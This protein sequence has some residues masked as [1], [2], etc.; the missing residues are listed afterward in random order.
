MERVVSGMLAF[1]DKYMFW[2]D[3]PSVTVID[4]VEIILI[5]FLLY[6]ILVWIKNTRAWA[7]DRKSVV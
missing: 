6:R 4:V 7:L 3:I 2:M 1:R 5:A